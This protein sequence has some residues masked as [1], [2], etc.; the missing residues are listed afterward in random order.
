MKVCIMRQIV[1]LA[2]ITMSIIRVK[3]EVFTNTYILCLLDIV[4]MREFF[5]FHL[6]I[7]HHANNVHYEV[8]T[9]ACVYLWK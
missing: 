1:E 8:M 9:E 5:Y 7:C 2:N 6:D 4:P 3:T